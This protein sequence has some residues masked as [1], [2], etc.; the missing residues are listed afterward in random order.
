MGIT[1]MEALWL[2]VL[3]ARHGVEEQWFVK[4]SFYLNFWWFIV[5]KS[6]KQLSDRS[7]D[8]SLQMW[9]KIQVKYLKNGFPHLVVLKTLL[10][11][12]GSTCGI[13]PL[14]SEVVATPTKATYQ[15]GDSISLSCP[16]GSVL[17]GE[18]SNIMCS[19]S[20]QWSPSPADVHCK[21]GMTHLF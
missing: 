14:D 17:E 11:V 15:I 16:V 20:L 19:P 1:F 13:P 18:V 6:Q 5:K 4:V 12:P 10:L 3:R 2:N 9:I 21:P 8:L 7:Q